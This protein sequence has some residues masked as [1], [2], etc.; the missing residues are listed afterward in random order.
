MPSCPPSYIF[1][2][3]FF[4]FIL[5]LLLL[6]PFPHPYPCVFSTTPRSSP[7]TREIFV[8]I[9][10]PGINIPWSRE[11]AGCEGTRVAGAGGRGRGDGRS[12]GGPRGV[13]AC[14]PRSRNNG[15]I[16]AP[17]PPDS[18]TSS[19]LKTHPLSL[20]L[21]FHAL[22]L[23]PVVSLSLSL[24]R[25][26]SFFLYPRSPSLLRNLGTALKSHSFS[27]VSDSRDPLLSYT[28]RRSPS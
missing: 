9:K 17:L 13:R 20:F 6:L 3:L 24:P 15:S 23:R 8:R 26:L 16:T 18:I 27:P 12:S 19:P 22:F 21:P 10:A 5:F 11:G 4:Y 7:G 1:L 28:R 2:H 25:A 14:L